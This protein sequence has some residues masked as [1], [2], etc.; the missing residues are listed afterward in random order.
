MV[1]TERE[2]ITGVWGRA[3]SGVQGQSPWS[4]GQGQSPLKLNVFLHYHNLV[5]RPVCP[6]IC[7]KQKI[8]RIFGDIASLVPP[9]SASGIWVVIESKM[10]AKE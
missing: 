5:N 4:E 7:F 8:R 1:S 6:K 3:P 10:V 9:E 2:P